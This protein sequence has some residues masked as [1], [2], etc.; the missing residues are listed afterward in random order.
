MKN[1]LQMELDNSREAQISRLLW[2]LKMQKPTEENMKRQEELLEELY[3]LEREK[4]KQGKLEEKK[5]RIKDVG[6]IWE[7][8]L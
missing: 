1:P 3:E 6:S 4:K 7:H 2:A 8:L 5:K